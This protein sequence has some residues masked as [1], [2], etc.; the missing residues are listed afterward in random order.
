MEWNPKVN[1][2]YAENCY[3]HG[4]IQ[5]FECDT[6][7][8]YVCIDLHIVYIV[9]QYWNETQEAFVHRLETVLM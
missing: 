6:S 7:S 9:Y 8:G 5:S 4:Q 1:N 3:S 2:I